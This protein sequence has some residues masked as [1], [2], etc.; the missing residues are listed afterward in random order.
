MSDDDLMRLPA[1]MAKTG[2]RR[3]TLYALILKGG[4]PHPIRLTDR[5]VAWPRSQVQ[6]F[7]DARIEAGQRKQAA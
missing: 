1:V 7:V 4:F 6:A 3:S 5:A 2:L